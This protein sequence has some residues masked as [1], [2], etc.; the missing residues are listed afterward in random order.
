MARELT[1]RQ[2]HILKFIVRGVRAGRAPTVREIMRQFGL[3]SPAPVSDI[4]RALEAKGFIRRPTPRQSRGITLVEAMVAPLFPAKH[5]DIQ[6]VGMI[7]AGKPVF[8]DPESEEWLTVMDVMPQAN[9]ALRIEGESMAL[10]ELHEGDYA[11]VRSQPW[12]EPGQIVVAQI[13]GEGATVKRYLERN[14]TVI[15]QPENPVFEPII[16]DRE[17]VTI[18]GVVVGLYRRL[19]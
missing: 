3:T 9:F 2:H 6:V 18:V 17:E 19:R 10:A 15:L 4:L 1:E 16:V 8:A 14:G 11:L 5:K 7:R 12:A 13:D